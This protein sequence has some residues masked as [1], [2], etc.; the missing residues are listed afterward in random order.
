[1][2]GTND[3]AATGAS[4]S[5]DGVQVSLSALQIEALVAL[6]TRTGTRD[7]GLDNLAHELSRQ[8]SNSAD[9]AVADAAS[10][11]AAAQAVVQGA[12]T[13]MA[14]ERQAAGV[15]A[16]TAN[17]ERSVATAALTAAE[18]AA[19]ARLVK[20]GAAADAAQD[21]ADTAAQT[22]VGVEIRAEALAERVAFAAE[23]A[24]QTVS[25]S[26]VS[27]GGTEAALIALR[28]AATVDAA[29]A[30]DFEKE[31]ADAASAVRM[32]ATITARDLA[33][34]TDARAVEVALAARRA[35]SAG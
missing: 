29:V 6:I 15:A 16:A 2:G 4:D 20:A 23:R 28:L 13:D 34:D 32:I 30:A 21:V 12:Q 31:V 14:A 27:G 25:A 24:A 1:M 11:F 10:V 5:D 33:V 35:A 26:T 22:A 3:P 7:A 17:T 8:Q 9:P 19:H 18:A